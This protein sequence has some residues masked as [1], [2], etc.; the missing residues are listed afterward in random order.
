MNKLFILL[1][2][3]MLC[4]CVPDAVTKGRTAYK[5]YFS[6]TLK[7]PTSLVIHKE[8]VI[9]K[10]ELGATFVLDV[11]AK[12]GFGAMVRH[13]YTIQTIGKSIKDV[14][15]YDVRTLP[16][17]VPEDEEPFNFTYRVKMLPVAGFEPEKCIGKEYTLSDSCV[18]CVSDISLSESIEAAKKR[19]GKKV[20]QKGGILP[21]GT[22]VKIISV[23]N[24]AFGV[25][26]YIYGTKFTTYIEQ[27]SIF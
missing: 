20:D 16:K 8:E 21:S 23:G 7:D 15:E 11:G 14:M 6:E 25:E 24:G 27:T 17:S 19:D 4:S 2:I 13:T 5:D 18:Y 26:Y 9:A 22:K 1:L 3:P 10:D 12:N